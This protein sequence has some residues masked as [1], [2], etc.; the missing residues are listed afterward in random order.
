MAQVH[1]VN[2][3][4]VEFIEGMSDLKTPAQRLAYVVTCFTIYARQGP[5]AN[6]AE[7]LNKSVGLKRTADCRRALDQLIAMG[8]LQ[9]TTDNK[10]TN[11]RCEIELARSRRR[12][13]GLDRT[14]P[15]LV[16]NASRS[17]PDLEGNSA[18]I[19]GLDH[20]HDATTTTTTKEVSQQPPPSPVAANG[21]G[22]GALTA[23]DLERVKGWR[24]PDDLEAD[25]RKQRPDLIER[26]I[27][28]RTRAWRQ[29][30]I[31]NGMPRDLAKSWFGWMLKTERR[32]RGG[33][34][35]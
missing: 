34:W 17:R 30:A 8:K 23:A 25:L 24:V 21:R 6:D 19:N 18:K 15:D 2:L 14:R 12:M 22:G 13:S 26:Q 10:L 11:K 20:S 1:V 27:R 3:N 16:L 4:A 32:R 31:A 28:E 35:G 5:I 33:I 29:Y 7:W 9:V